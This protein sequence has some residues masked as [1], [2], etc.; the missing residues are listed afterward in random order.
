MAFEIEPL[1]IARVLVFFLWDVVIHNLV[2]DFSSMFR[3]YQQE[4][5]HEFMQCVLDK[6][7]RCFIDLKKN[8]KSFEDDNLVEKVFG[9]RFI[10]KV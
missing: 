5:A 8:S 3:R 6:L 1:I 4:D 10:S 9:G 7:E 2:T